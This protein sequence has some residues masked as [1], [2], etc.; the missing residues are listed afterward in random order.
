MNNK[1]NRYEEYRERTQK[2]YN[3]FPQGFAF[4]SKQLEEQMRKLGVTDKS[5]LI[6]I[7]YGGFIRKTDKQAYLEMIRETN[8]EKNKL[9]ADD[10]DGSGF[11]FDM[12]YSELNNNEY[13]YTYDIED[14]L[15]AL[16]YTEEDIQND[17][18]LANGLSKAIASIVGE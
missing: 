16:G 9:I 10:K 13:S 3:E 17:K 12:F 4:S 14:T 7:G 2:R 11:I 8:E 1:I 5:E 6:S 18:R 15:D